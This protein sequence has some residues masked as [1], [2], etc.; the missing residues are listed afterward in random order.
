MA[1]IIRSPRGFYKKKHNAYFLCCGVVALF[2]LENFRSSWH[3]SIAKLPV[4]CVEIFDVAFQA[5]LCPGFVVAVRAD[6]LKVARHVK[7][8]IRLS[9]S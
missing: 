9:G 8:K 5:T 7:I 4:V 1:T 6:M 3:S 2:T